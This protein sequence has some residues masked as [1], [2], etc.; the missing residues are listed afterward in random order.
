MRVW[1]CW[2]SC[3]NVCGRKLTESRAEQLCM[4]SVRALDIIKIYLHSEDTALMFYSY[5]AQK[6]QASTG[7]SP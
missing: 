6:H 1:R 4:L 5:Q 7:V 2:W 3:E